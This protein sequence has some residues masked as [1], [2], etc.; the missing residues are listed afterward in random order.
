MGILKYCCINNKESNINSEIIMKENNKIEEH[1]YSSSNNS[2][3]E[4]SKFK[5]KYFIPIFKEYKEKSYNGFNAKLSK[6]E[7]R[8]K[9]KNEDTEYINMYTS[10]FNTS[11]NKSNE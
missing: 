10:N 5:R 6:S 2:Y 4:K 7:S 1:I 3:N 11:N 8:N 9:Y